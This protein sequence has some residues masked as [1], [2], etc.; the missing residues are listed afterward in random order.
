VYGHSV[1]SEEDRDDAD[2]ALD[3]G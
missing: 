3:D 2:G 1:W